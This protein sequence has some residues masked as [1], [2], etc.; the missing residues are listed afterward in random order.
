MTLDGLPHSEISGSKRVCR[1][2]K[3]IAA[4]RVLR[5]L[6]MPR[7][8]LCA[9]TILTKILN[10]ALIPRRDIFSRSQYAVVKERTAFAV[11]C[12]PRGRDDPSERNDRGGRAWNR[13]RDL[14]L[15]RDAL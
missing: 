5:R 9:L 3:L 10:L 4:Y 15:I 8:P 6:L 2:P 14:V 11:K 1:S 13:T 7:H 12:R